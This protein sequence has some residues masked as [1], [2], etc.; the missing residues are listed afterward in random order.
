MIRENNHLS[1]I[2]NEILNSK[3]LNTSQIIFLK[4]FSEN[5]NCKII[6]LTFQI[7]KSHDV[8]PL[9]LIFLYF[10]NNESKKCCNLTYSWINLTYEFIRRTDFYKYQLKK[11]FKDKN[12]HDIPYFSDIFLDIKSKRKI[13]DENL[14]TLF[15]FLSNL[16][17]NSL[18]ESIFNL[19]RVIYKTKFTEIKRLKYFLN[20][21]FPYLDIIKIYKNFDSNV[22]LKLMKTFSIIKNIQIKTKKKL[23]KIL[24]NHH[25]FSIK[26][27]GKDLKRFKIAAIKYFEFKNSKNLE[28]ERLLV[29]YSYL[30]KKIEKN[31]D[32]CYNYKI[33]KLLIQ[34]ESIKKTKR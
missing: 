30:E 15:K 13:Y 18:L 7:V 11:I 23:T 21:L 27:K 33:L 22:D 10:I 8:T 1:D 19:I 34:S 20:Y 29:E 16:P 9:S 4:N 3:N 6:N 2:I 5:H 28:N 26:L 32:K 14:N 25:K 24:Q 12:Y 17:I 31:P